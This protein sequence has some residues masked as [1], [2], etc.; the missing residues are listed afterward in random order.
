[1]K[2][3]LAV[4][5]LSLLPFGAG[6]ALA[7]SPGAPAPGKLQKQ[8]SHGAMSGSRWELGAQELLFRLSGGKLWARVVLAVLVIS[9]LDQTLCRW[10]AM[11]ETPPTDDTISVPQFT[12]QPSLDTTVVDLLVDGV[13]LRIPRNY[14][15]TARLTKKYIDEKRHRSAAALVIITTFPDFAGATANTIHLFSSVGPRANAIVINPLGPRA[16]VR[17]VRERNEAALSEAA[18]VQTRDANGLIKVVAKTSLTPR[19]VYVGY[20]HNFQHGAVISCVRQEDREIPQHCDVY[21]EVN[22]L[23]YLYRYEK[24]LLPSWQ[25]IQNGIVALLNSFH[26]GGRQ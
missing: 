9:M 20:D 2:V 7:Q 25:I 23:P 21:L 26:A 10:T 19:D 14:L 3:H 12:A 4:I 1:M 18:R 16:R 8:P 6:G 5:V 17:A 11:A 13:P 22:G 24:A 15:E